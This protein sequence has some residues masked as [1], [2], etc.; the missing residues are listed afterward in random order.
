MNAGKRQLCG[1]HKSWAI[2][3]SI[4][5]TECRRAIPPTGFE[6]TPALGRLALL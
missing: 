2:G 1:S 5:R 3:M 4:P 6:L